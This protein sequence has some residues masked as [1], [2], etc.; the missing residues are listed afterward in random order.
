MKFLAT[1]TI[2]TIALTGL[3]FASP[4]PN[5][6][7]IMTDDQGWGQTGYYKHPVLKTPNLDAMAA[8]GLRFDRF[9][10]G[11]P[12]CS[13]TRASVLTG[14]ANNRTGVPSHGHA[15]RL[16]EKTIAAA[17]KQAG[18]ATGHF[19]KWHL[20][21]LRGPGAP[22]L[23]ED[24]Y[25]PK[26]FGFE[27]W[28]TVTNFFDLDPLMGSAQGVHQFKGDSSEII[29]NQAL[30]FIKKQ[31]DAEK[32][33]LVVIWDGSPH[34]PFEAS[35]EDIAPFKDLDKNSQKT[36][37]RARRLRPQCRGPP[38]D[39]P[40]S[41]NRRRHSWS[42]SA[43]TTAGSQKSSPPPWEISAATKALFTKAACASP[44]SSNGPPA[45]NPASRPTPP[46]RWTSSQPSP[47][48]SNFPKI[49]FSN[50]STENHSKL[51]SPRTSKDAPTP[52]PFRYARPREPS[53]TT[54]TNWSPR[55]CRRMHSPSTI[56]PPTPAKPRTS[57]K[58][59]TEQFQKMTAH[60]LK[61]YQSVEDSIA[62][63][64]YP[65]DFDPD[66]VPHPKFWT[67]DKRYQKRFEEWKKYPGFQKIYK[68]TKRRDR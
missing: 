28:M 8:N 62:G 12:V 33:F 10:A 43:A 11:A 66:S 61:W 6:I 63:K 7:L 51:S 30:S 2:L 32:P 42:G 38:Q 3:S 57:P 65:G 16:Q 59:A 1:I 56:S 67:S 64:D 31:K 19:G 44:P 45:S 20:N 22:I 13:P 23:D 4:R 41:Q 15:L 27:T 40:R 18:Y 24:P 34:S 52:I 37:R 54:T 26:G 14:R 5:I 68:E 46:R 50:P 36:L 55:T 17:L 35:E 60:Y 29:V 48:S 58:N 53:S 39:P 21:G 47:T 25:G 9:Y 49:A